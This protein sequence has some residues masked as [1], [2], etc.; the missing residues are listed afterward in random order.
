[1]NTLADI[2][3]GLLFALLAIGIPIRAWL[4]KDAM[5]KA[6]ESD[7]GARLRIYRRAGVAKIILCAV[8]LGVYLA[9]GRNAGGL[10][11]LPHGFQAWLTA[12][13]VAGVFVAASTAALRRPLDP[14]R[15]ERLQRKVMSSPTMPRTAEERRA[16]VGVSINAGVTEELL[17]RGFVLGFL[18]EVA[19]HAGWPL[20]VVV[21]AVMFG[22]AHILQGRRGVI[23]TALVGAWLGAV[24]LGSGLLLAMLVHTL[25]DLN[26][27]RVLAKVDGYDPATAPT[28]TLGTRTT[29]ARTRVL[30]ALVAVA[31]LMVLL[32][33]SVH[34]KRPPHYATAGAV[35][36]K[37]TCTN[38]ER[39]TLS[40]PTITSAATCT[41]GGSEV[42]IVT[43]H[44]RKALTASVG[45]C[46]FDSSLCYPV[47][48]VV[49][50]D[51][52]WV[53]ASS[54]NSCDPDVGAWPE[55]ARAIAAATGGR[56]G[57]IYCLPS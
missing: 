40:D 54:P 44:D 20:L 39:T 41:V 15:Y 28:A 36:R 37:M 12:A 51:N 27:L 52:W 5:R 49:L 7:P 17:Y 25:L 3:A 6:V 16:W 21:S 35:A 32:L 55:Q 4:R 46:H 53:G 23:L 42:S 31:L 30:G 10:R 34:V 45:S 8:A 1:M 13:L 38:V 26:L 9:S 14:A 19:P 22:F 11:L 48:S 18:H 29:T 56:L 47:H 2:V 33:S 43:Y 57:Y 24:A 50:G